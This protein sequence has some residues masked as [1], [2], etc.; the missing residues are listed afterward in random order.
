M[1]GRTLTALVVAALVAVATGA[2]LLQ[3]RIDTGTSSFLPKGDPAHAALEEKASIFGGDPIVV[4][5]ESAEPRT[6]LGDTNELR[7]LLKLEGALSKLPDVAAVYGPGTILN[8]TAGAA[9]NMLA[10]ISG[11]R[12]AIQ[13]IAENK[14]RAEGASGPEVQ[15]AGQSAIKAFDERY[16]ALLVRGLPAGLPTLRNPRFVETV[17]FDENGRPRPQWHFVVPSASSVAVLVRPRQELDQDAASRL[18]DAVRLAVSSAGLSTSRTTV[19][20]VPVLTAALTDR[21][22]A[23][24][25]LLGGL[26]VLV[27]GLIFL[28]APWSSRRRSRLRPVAAALAGTA[29]TVAVFGWTGHELSLGVVAF[30]PILLGI[31]SDFPFYLSRRGEAR[32]VVVA[33]L[34]AA[35]GFGSLA[36]SPL[37]FVRELGIALAL[38]IVLTVG[39]AWGMRFVLGPVAEVPAR[40]VAVPA[41]LR[42][43]ALLAGALVLAALGWATLPGLDIE[44]QPEQ[45][46]RGLDELADAEYAEQLLGSSGEVNIAVTGDD[47][48]DPAVLA[49]AQEAETAIVRAHG[50][51]LRPVL[52]MG[53]LFGFLGANATP[54]QVASATEVVPRYLTSAV[55]TSDRRHGLLIFGVEFDDVEELGSLLSSLDEVIP[56]APAGVSVDVVGLPVAAAR[57]LDLVSEGRLWMNIAGILAAVLVL[58]LGLRGWRDATRAA[59][60]VLI[61]TGWVF[62]IVYLTTG[63]LSPLTVAIGSLT[64]AVGCEFAVML[65]RRSGLAGVATAALAGTAGYLVLGFSELA[66]LRDFGVF[67][68]AGVACSFAAAVVTSGLFPARTPFRAHVPSA[69]DSPDRSLEEVLT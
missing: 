9:Q 68:A 22:R 45:L 18:A 10:R 1:R 43:P 28:L 3:V 19:T 64:T 35:V 5:L 62:S 20:G 69:V 55:V 46:A 36:L 32:P 49:W 59:L 67:L 16:G 52:T 65:A 29:G 24:L 44:A 56:P 58:A 63:S 40:T 25:P 34:A 27:V 21:A 7:A 13:K 30:L 48:L 54:E 8:Q 31:G 15:A 53:D 12:D 11:R 2:G 39:V 23:E 41:P 26:S 66:V 57:G 6:L 60:T 51:Q 14:A 61:A 42:S 4:V 38:G 47:V 37:P 33:G 17:L 50:D